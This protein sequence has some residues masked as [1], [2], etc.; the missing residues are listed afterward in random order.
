MPPLT[1]QQTRAILADPDFAKLAVGRGR[2]RW[3]LS[4]ATLMMFF[5]FI[6][7]IVSAKD[8]LGTSIPGSAIP[9]GLLLALSSIVLVV[10]LTGIYVQRSNTRF[11]ELARRLNKEFG[12]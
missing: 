11:D 12:R 4:A 7:L 2:L 1:Q 5:G 8:P 3:M 10:V 6:A 9:V